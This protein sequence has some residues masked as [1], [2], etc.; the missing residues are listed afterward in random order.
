MKWR[1]KATRSAWPKVTTA[2][3]EAGLKP[4]ARGGESAAAYLQNPCKGSAAEFLQR[5][6]ALRSLRIA[7]AVHEQREPV[8]AH[9]RAF[10]PEPEGWRRRRARHRGHGVDL[11]QRL[12]VRV[13]DDE[14]R[15]LSEAWHNV[16]SRSVIGALRDEDDLEARARCDAAWNEAT[17]LYHEL[18]EKIGERLRLL[19]AHWTE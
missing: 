19:I 12:R 1:P 7:E 14:L 15:R 5:E 3:A 17:E 9:R 4:P 18:M 2:S 11:L 8:H 16:T 10:A 13:L 6:P